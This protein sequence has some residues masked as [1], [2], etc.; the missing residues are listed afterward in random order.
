MMDELC[1]TGHTGNYQTQKI[2]LIPGP[3]NVSPH[4]KLKSRYH[5]KDRQL[6]ANLESMQN[7]QG[8]GN[9]HQNMDILPMGDQLAFKQT[10]CLG[11]GLRADS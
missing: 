7:I 1:H 11:R 5:T 3:T 8:A 6:L 10:A 4:I 2:N 9:D